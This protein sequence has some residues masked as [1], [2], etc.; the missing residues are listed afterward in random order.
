M[1]TR[2]VPGESVS[3]LCPTLCDSMVCP[4]GPPGKNT[5]GG[6]PFPSLGDLPNFRGSNPDLLH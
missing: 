5:R 3:C 4:R 2:A 1:G 6:L